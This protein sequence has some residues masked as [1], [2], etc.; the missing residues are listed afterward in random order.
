MVSR[1]ASKKIVD[2]GSGPGFLLKFLL[3][4]DP[5]IKVQGIDAAENLVEIGRKLCD[6]P[7]IVGDYLTAEPDDAYELIDCNFGFDEPDFLPSDTPHSSAQ[8]GAASYC[9]GCSDDLK[10][11]VEVYVR[12][13]RR[14]GTS[15]ASLAITG[16]ILHFGQLR[17]LYWQLK[18]RAGALQL[19]IVPC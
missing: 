8:C 6:V 7:L 5:A 10:A 11:Q 19:K 15:S 4:N 16:R 14:W 3:E 17:H 9:P 1:S 2:V 13:W 12:A 18:K